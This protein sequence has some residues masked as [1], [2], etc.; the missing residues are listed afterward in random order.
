M[1]SASKLIA[2][3]GDQR[4]DVDRV[5]DRHRAAIVGG[6]RIAGDADR[7]RVAE[8]LVGDGDGAVDRRDVLRRAVARA[9]RDRG[10]VGGAGDRRH[11]V[12]AGDRDHQVLRADIA[13]AVIDLGHVGQRQRVASAQP[14][15]VGRRRVVVPVDRLLLAIREAERIE[16][17]RAD[18]I[19]A[20][21][22]T[23]F[24]TGTAPPLYKAVALPVTLTVSVSPTSWSVIEVIVP[25]TGGM[26]CA[27]L[28]P[29]LSAIA[30]GL[31][32]PVDGRHVVG[33]GDGDHQVLGADIAVAVIDLGHVGQRQRVASAQPVE[34]GR[35]RVVGPVD[36]LLLRRR[37]RAS[38][39]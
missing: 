16:A 36:R 11:V 3:T 1:P 34:V 30:A 12:G 22:S 24:S 33:A 27:E 31:V 28:S 13:L 14:V 19:S 4:R 9:L 7:Q 8:I 32:A 38:R 21:T 23:E 29:A 17:D 10:R 2:P 6:G 37:T 26:S 5:L 39:S 35:R 25:S 15:E 18:A 20:A